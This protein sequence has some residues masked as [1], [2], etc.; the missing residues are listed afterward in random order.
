MFLPL[1]LGCQPKPA[2][3]LLADWLGWLALQVG[4]LHIHASF[5]PPQPMHHAYTHARTSAARPQL[6]CPQDDSISVRE[7]ALE[8]L[9]RHISGNQRLAMRLFPTLAKASTGGTQA[10]LGMGVLCGLRGVAV[11]TPAPPGVL[12]I[13]PSNKGA[14]IC[15]AWPRWHTRMPRLPLP[16]RLWHQ[17]AQA[18]HPH[19][20]G[21]LHPC[22]RL[23]SRH[24]GVQ[25]RADAR[26]RR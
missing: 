17:R 25:T 6:A 19:P 7:A 4:S 3:C 9:G 22:P 5:T 16:R 21:V 18:R 20:V 12:Y 8:L 11:C 24:G 10:F 23:P 15:R 2:A 1:A 26:W 14:A 13:C